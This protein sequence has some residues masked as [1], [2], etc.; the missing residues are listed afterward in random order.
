MNPKE[1][2]QKIKKSI[3]RR[4][5]YAIGIIILLF[6]TTFSID[7]LI[8]IALVIAFILFLAPGAKHLYDIKEV[9]DG[10]IEFR[11]F[12]F[13]LKKKVMIIKPLHTDK[14]EVHRRVF[15]LLDEKKFLFKNI[16]M[17][18]FNW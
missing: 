4:Y 10:K 8:T 13:F 14:F 6:V 1:R 16:P 12:S 7:I 5:A 11:Y 18:I 3:I 9:A 2:E 17:T 15:L